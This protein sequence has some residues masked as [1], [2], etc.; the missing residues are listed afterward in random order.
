MNGVKAK[1]AKKISEFLRQC[2]DNVTGANSGC[3]GRERMATLEVRAELAALLE[4]YSMGGCDDPQRMLSEFVDT[5]VNLEN[6]VQI[7]GGREESK[8]KNVTV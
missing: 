7:L 2:L 1:K 4:L 3:D 6:P 8:S 5:P